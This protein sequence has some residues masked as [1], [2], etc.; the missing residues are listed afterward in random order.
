MTEPRVSYVAW[1]GGHGDL[2]ADLYLGR[3]HSRNVPAY[4]IR[5]VLWDSAFG[6]VNG[7]PL[8]AILYYAITR[9]LNRR[10]SVW[11]MKREGITFSYS[12]TGMPIP[13]AIVGTTQD[14]RPSDG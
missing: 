10:L 6:Y 8:S 1:G 4:G 13:H 14:A 12:Q 3:G 5:R 9:S 2:P 7:F 11:A